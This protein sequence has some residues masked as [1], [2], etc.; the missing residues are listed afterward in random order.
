MET[1]EPAKE[2]EV[3]VDDNFHFM[4]ESERSSMG[5]FATLR[6]ALSLCLEIIGRDILQGDCEHK[7]AEEI[8]N[9]YMMMGEDPH[10]VG[11]HKMPFSAWD[12][13]KDLATALAGKTR[14]DAVPAEQQFRAGWL[15]GF[16]S[17]EN[18]ATP[19]VAY[20]IFEAF[21]DSEQDEAEG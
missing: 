6:E 17:F 8:N 12:Y 20:R 3:L 16:L 19:E 11:P 15:A 1:N 7:T 13:A 10:I 2:Y 5:S 21:L 4:D 9:A 14:S 18:K